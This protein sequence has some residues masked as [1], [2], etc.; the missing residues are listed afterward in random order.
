M[1]DKT[2]T[3]VFETLSYNGKY[4]IVWKVVVRVVPT[5]TGIR[6][7]NP[8]AA[9][10]VRIAANTRDKADF[11]TGVHYKIRYLALHHCDAIGGGVVMAYQHETLSTKRRFRKH[12]LNNHK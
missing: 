5:G 8:D 7:G 10:W 1:Q 2:V 6:R 12:Q 3:S 11:S 9:I 4:I